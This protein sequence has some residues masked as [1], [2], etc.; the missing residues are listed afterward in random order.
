MATFRSS[1]WQAHVERDGF[2]DQVKSFEGKAEAERWAGS[3]ESTQP[4][5]TGL[6]TLHFVLESA[7]FT[8]TGNLAAGGC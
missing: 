2:P 5:V 3:V 6:S 7:P 1:K 8:T 4:P